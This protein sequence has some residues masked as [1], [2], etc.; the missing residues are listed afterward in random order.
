MSSILTNNGAIVALQTLKSINSNLNKTQ[1]QVST[2]KA[3]NNAQDNAAIWA[4]SKVMETDK[5]AFNAIQSNLNV[6]EATVATART[7]AEQVANL[8]QEMKDLAIS[9]GADT[10]DFGKIQTDIAAKKA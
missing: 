9:A 2:G 6:A 7:G 8:L 5:S 1:E 3:V 10:A 4:I